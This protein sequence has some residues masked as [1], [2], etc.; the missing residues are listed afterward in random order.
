MKNRNCML[1]ML[2]MAALCCGN[3]AEAQTIVFV[4]DRSGNDEIYVMNSDGS[5]QTNITNT[6]SLEDYPS[7]SPDG[8]KIVFRTNRDG[9]N[10]DIYTM[11]ADGSNPTRLTNDPAMD[12]EPAWSPD[13]S[14][15]AFQANR[16]DNG[17]IYVMNTDGSNQTRLT[18][19][20]H[21][22]NYPS[23]SPDGSKIAFQTNRDG[24]T[25]IYVMNS[26]GSNQT[27]LSINSAS[28][29]NPS[30]SPDGLTIVFQSERDGNTEIYIMNTDGSNQARITNNTSR[31][32]RP[33]WSSDGSKIAFESSRDGNLEIY[34]MNSDGTNQIRLTNNSS[35]DYNQKWARPVYVAPVTLTSPNGAES[36]TASTTQNITWTCTKEEGNVRLE[37]STDGGSNWTKIVEQ[38]TTSVGSYLWTVPDIQSDNCKV[39]ITD[40]SDSNITDQS[41]GVFS[42][43]QDKQENITIINP[44][45]GESWTTNNVHQITWTS[46][47]EEGN[48]RLEYSTDGGSNWTKIVEQTTTSVGSYSWTVPN[49]SSTNCRIRITDSSDASITDQSDA[50]F[51]ISGSLSAPSSLFSIPGNERISLNWN[52]NTES[53]LKYYMIYRNAALIDSVD[54]AKTTY[55]DTG[56]TNG[57]TYTYAITAVDSFNNESAAGTAVSD[58]P[59]ALVWDSAKEII[60]TAAL[61]VLDS[62]PVP[63]SSP[64]GMAW[65]GTALWIVDTLK[66]VY[67]ISTSGEVLSSFAV[68]FSSSGLVWDGRHLWF[69]DQSNGRLAQF[70]TTGTY[71]GG[72]DI[73]YWANS[74]ITW[75]GE[76]FWV[77][78]YNSSEI[79]KHTSAGEEVLYWGIPSSSGIEHPTGM[80][81]DGSNLWIGDPNE[82]SENN[83]TKLST[84]GQLLQSFDTNDIGIA[85][86]SWPEVKTLAWDGESLWYS[87]SDLF[88]VY[89][90]GTSKNITLTSPNDSEKWTSGTTQNITWTSENVENVMIEYSVDGARTWTMIVDSTPAADGSY[91]WTVAE[92][93]SFNCHVRIT[94]TTDVTVTDKNDEIF[95]IQPPSNATLVL[96]SP[97]GFEVWEPGSVQAI[98][99]KSTDIDIIHIHFSD[100]AFLRNT[101]IAESVDAS[102]GVYYWTVPDNAS[103]Q[104]VIWIYYP[105]D[106]SVQDKSDNHFS[107]GSP[108]IRL[109]DD[110]S[111]IGI[112]A[113]GKI[114]TGIVTLYNDGDIEL[115]VSSISSDNSEFVVSH[116][117]VVIQ[118][119]DHVQVAVTFTPTESG[120]KSAVITIES[121]DSDEGTLTIQANARGVDEGAG[122]TITSPNGGETWES[123]TLRQITWNSNG[124]ETVN[125]HCTYDGGT[126][127]PW[128]AEGVDASTGSYYWTV[129]GAASTSCKVWIYDAANTDI[130]DGS[131]EFFSIG[132]PDIR[133]S[134]NSIDIGDVDVGG[135]GLGILT[136]YNDGNIPL[137]VTSITSDNDEFTVNV[138]SVTINPGG[139]YQVAITVQPSESGEQWANITIESIDN[140]EGSQNV[141][142]RVNATA[143]EINLS[144]DTLEFDT[145]DVGSSSSISF[146]IYNEGGKNLVVNSINSDNGSFSVSP[147]SVTIG[148][149]QSHSVNVTF[150]PGDMSEQWGTISIESD[151]SDE[152][153]LTVSVHGTGIA[154]DIRLSTDTISFDG[155]DVNSSTNTT[156]EI[157]NDGNRQ[158]NVHNINSNNS[159]FSVSPASA[160]INP[161]NNIQVTVTFSPSDMGDQQASINISS[162]DNDEGSLDIAVSGTGL[163]AEIRLSTEN[164]D[165]SNV[166]IGSSGSG[167]FDIYNDGNKDLEVSDIS[168]DNG[169]FTVSS[170]SATIGPQQNHT[171][172]VNFTPTE[173]DD[174]SA[175]ITIT[176]ND[177][178]EPSL[179][180]NVNGTGL[181]PEINLTYSEIHLG[182]VDVTTSSSSSFDIQNEGN[183]DLTVDSITSDNEVF[184]VSEQSM[185][186]NPGQTHTVTVTFAPNDQ[187]EQSATITIQSNDSD[188]GTLTVTANGTGYDQEINLSVQSIDIGDVDVGTGGTGSF[189]ITN[190]GNKDLFVNSI[191]SDNGDAEVSH[192]SATI[193]PGNDLEVTVTFTPVGQGEQWANI[194]VNSDDR[195]ENS[196]SVSV[197]ING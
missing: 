24:D 189:T 104:C 152:G 195:D 185:T 30:W 99:W 103:T 92:A 11:D 183:K 160:D 5:T 16:D 128:V 33:T 54:A 157:Y 112:V 197:R 141:S 34:T 174:R 93:Q 115:T 149:N 144:T 25:E 110:T 17:E 9:N 123:G 167:T 142:V 42:I 7:W 158:L 192:G 118:P 31:D 19:N 134:S 126:T 77:A 27:N 180:V 10:W 178:D 170:S 48:V 84:T 108:D 35:S 56:L 155:I 41:N 193:N 46:S 181:A 150:N 188:E 133:L 114:G 79:H 13:N 74:G 129:P 165:I 94:D 39:R 50:V 101:R 161:G 117:S 58:S 95:Q 176:S 81:F 186:I 71:R 173:R 168:S 38:T 172:T 109:S 111:D 49:V 78:D 63:G 29:N 68:D 124:I 2:G 105:S 164:V 82:G 159:N 107:I 51:T 143:P 47:K 177:S 169:A 85:P 87:A 70:D 89:K 72:F 88:Y 6:S 113:L 80:T 91:S 32:R 187:G 151:D 153:S 44:N 136:I 53:N 90:I 137:D 162:N 122:I 171:V 100:N 22:D 145:V 20:A 14:K 147:S 75:D 45:G 127:Y 61:A 36:W 21:N 121:N 59:I 1:L 67:H 139:L 184:S 62:F 135:E 130:T 154:P 96:T 69:A 28:D 120:E 194:A 140:D 106:I 179:N 18:N 156:F 66:N 132:T 125:I 26:D 146:D 83:I 119:G 3:F 175:T 12:L 15:I 190:E 97:N 52:A 182:N 65:D 148:P 40:S 64:V 60:D 131:D 138:G 8:S 4:S 98:T 166:D 37:Y 196:L 43:T 191:N 73:H 23:W 102:T 163:A 55:T 76:F 116:D 57:Q 86:Q